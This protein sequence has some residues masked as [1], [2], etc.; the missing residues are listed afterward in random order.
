MDKPWTVSN[1]PIIATERDV[2]KASAINA[3][4]V[5]PIGVLPTNPGDPVRPFAVGLFNDMRPLVKPDIGLMR[6]RRAIAA[7]AHSKR[8]YFATAQPDAMRHD[9]AGMP[10]EPVSEADRLIAQQ[11]FLELKRTPVV[12]EHSAQQSIAPPPAPV[13]LTKAEQIRAALLK[14][15]KDA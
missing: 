14:R 5:C 3:L 7:Y 15:R 6:L 4:L 8:Y 2:E 1:G 10:V 13:P 9:L 11:R 12:P